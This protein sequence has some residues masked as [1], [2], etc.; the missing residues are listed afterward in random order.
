MAAS[1][2]VNPG[3]T[4]TAAQYNN[5]RKD[6]LHAGYYYVDAVGLDDTLPVS[7][8]IVGDAATAVFDSGITSKAYFEC[9]IPPGI[10]TTLD[11]LFRIGFDMRNADAGK[12]VYFQTDYNVIIDTGDTTP[13]SFTATKNEIVST[14]DTGETKKIVTLSTIKIDAA[15]LVAGATLVVRFSRLGADAN[16]TNTHDLRMFTME[17]IQNQP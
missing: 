14:P 2:K 13:A 6:A 4:A 16:D 12:Q 17:L 3:D 5:L 9:Q 11:W 10:D 1:A 7:E 8:E 15:D